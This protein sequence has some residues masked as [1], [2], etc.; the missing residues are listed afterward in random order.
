MA[1]S[2][3]YR[4]RSA[5]TEERKNEHDHD[6]QA[7]Q[8]NQTIHVRL[9]PKGNKPSDGSDIR[10]WYRTSKRGLTRKVPAPAPFASVWASGSLLQCSVPGLPAFKVARPAVQA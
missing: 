10:P 7:D 2:L 3:A 1:N 9:L 6:D 4:L 8:I 5:Q